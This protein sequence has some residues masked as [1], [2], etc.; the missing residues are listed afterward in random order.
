[1]D[2]T[3]ILEVVES[4]AQGIENLDISLV[5]VAAVAFIL[6]AIGALIGLIVYHILSRRWHA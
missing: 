1:M 6:F 5:E 2:N 3:Q 4:G